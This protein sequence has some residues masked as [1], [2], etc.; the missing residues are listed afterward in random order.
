MDYLRRRRVE[1]E[2]RRRVCPAR[3]KTYSAFGLGSLISQATSH[4]KF[5]VL[6]AAVLVMA[7]TVVAINRSFWKRFAEDWRPVLPLWG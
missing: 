4:G 6:A 7:L 5:D 3:G 1:R 2:Y